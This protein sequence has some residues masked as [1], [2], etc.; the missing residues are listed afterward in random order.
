M[1]E[2]KLRLSSAIRAGCKDSH[3]V[4]EVI[5]DGEDGRDVVAAAMVGAGFPK[6]RFIHD[7]REK[8]HDELRRKVKCPDCIQSG[9]V[10]DML[11]HMN[12]THK[13]SRELIADFLES[14][15]L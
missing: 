12:D 6:L 7:F 9:P 15:D 14:R 10:E 11:T 13:L 2:T 1:N 4:F 5:F 8:Y 3:Q